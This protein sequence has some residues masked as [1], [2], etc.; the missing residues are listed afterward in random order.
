ML[1][2]YSEMNTTTVFFCL[3]LTLNRFYPPHEFDDEDFEF[4]YEILNCNW[5]SR[6]VEVCVS[7]SFAAGFDAISIELIRRN[8]LI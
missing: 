7:Q 3:M 4:F 1:I 2:L 8:D 6:S 5:K